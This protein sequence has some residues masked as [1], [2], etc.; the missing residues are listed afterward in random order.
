LRLKLTDVNLPNDPA[1]VVEFALGSAF[2]KNWNAF[3]EAIIELGAKCTVGEIDEIEAKKKLENAIV[4]LENTDEI[5]RWIYG[6][7]VLPAQVAIA[8]AQ[9]FGALGTDWTTNF[10]TRLQKRS[11]GSPPS[12]RLTDI[13]AFEFM[14]RSSR[15]SLGQSVKQ[16]CPCEKKHTKECLGRFK[17]GI[18]SLKK[19]L[20][21]FAPD[22]VTRYDLLHPDRAR[23]GLNLK[24]L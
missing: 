20:R 2:I 24:R 10:A 11:Q 22:L 8:Q 19:I 5:Q 3:A 4:F 6:R 16:F 21:K 12:R 18:R 14:L 23:P 7:K 9:V 13:R 1:N 17:T 15:N